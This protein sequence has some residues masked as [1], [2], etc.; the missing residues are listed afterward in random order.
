MESAWMAHTDW[1]FY[2]RL[3][4]EGFHSDEIAGRAQAFIRILH[5][6]IEGHLS[7]RDGRAPNYEDYFSCLKQIVQDETG[8]IANPLIQDNATRLHNA[9]SSLHVGRDT[10]IN[11][12]TFAS[13]ADRAA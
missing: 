6:H 10:H 3:P 9:S 11:D 12:N 4:E 13:L 1:A 5:L 2:P 7:L 8:E